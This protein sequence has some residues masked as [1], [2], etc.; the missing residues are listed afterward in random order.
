MLKLRPI[1]FNCICAVPENY[2]SSSAH[3]SAY[4]I[5]FVA[6]L[7][8]SYPD[9]QVLLGQVFEHSIKQKFY[10][11]QRQHGYRLQVSSRSSYLGNDQ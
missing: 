3:E 11:C 4:C 9:E 8:K 10:D 5:N 6:F 2:P 1:L 7:K